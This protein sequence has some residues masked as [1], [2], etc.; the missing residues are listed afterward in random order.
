MVQ[1]RPLEA[2]GQFIGQLKKRKVV[3]VGFA[4]VIVAWVVMQFA[5][6]AVEALILPTWSLTLV[7][8]LL[9]LGLPVALVLAWAYEITPRGIVRDLEG[10]TSAINDMSTWASLPQSVS[11]EKPSIAVL[12]FEDMSREADLEY[13]CEGLAEE[14]IMTLSSTGAIRVADRMGSFEFGSKC[15]SA[16]EIGRKLGVSAFLEGSVRKD[17]RRL[18]VAV[19]LVDVKQGYQLWSGQ[20]DRR[21]EDMLDVQTDIAHGV[22]K[23]LQLTGTIPELSWRDMCKTQQAYEFYLRGRGYFSKMTKT[24]IRFARQM[25]QKVTD[26][27]PE[28]G[29]GW[30]QLACTYACEF[31]YFNASNDY[32]NKASIFSKKALDLA[33]ELAQSHIAR[34][35]AYSLFGDYEAAD[36]EFQQAIEIN[37]YLFDAWYL[38]ARCKVH[39]GDSGKAVKLFEKA[40]SLRPEDYQS[41]ILQA[42]QLH[43]LGDE[44]ASL[45]ALREGLAR[46]RSFLEFNPDDDRAWGLGAFALLTLGQED[47]ADTWMKNCLRHAARCSASTYNAACFYAR[48]GEFEKSLDFLEQSIG[49]GTISKQWIEQDTDLDT[50]RELPRFKEIMARYPN[51]QTTEESATQIPEKIV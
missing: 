33:P 21:I 46:A 34:G 42:A 27:D 8:I 35:T 41:P 45:S 2:L 9:I 7:V 44:E 5:D 30:A 50:V 39:Q 6:I 29:L 51:H 36:R 10:R 47:E 11:P 13:F 49:T 18:R 24:N 20:Y 12:P 25:F 23:S 48:K 31:L 4:Y 16:A 15:A 26:I 1:G 32:R 19:Q 17:G 14:I 3:R 38:N 28:C 22:V 40:A 37:P 43:K